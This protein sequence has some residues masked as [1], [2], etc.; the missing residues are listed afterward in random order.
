MIFDATSFDDHQQVVFCNDVASGL[1]AIIAIHRGGPKGQALG[2][3]RMI[4]YSSDEEALNDVLRLSRGMTY[5]S[6]VSNLALGGAKSVIIGDPATQK[7]PELL[8]AMGRF[9]NSLGGRYITSVD[10]GIGADDVG[11]MQ[12]VCDYAVGAGDPSPM[13]ALGVYTGVK[14]CAK[15]KLGTDDLKDVRVAVLG[16]GKVGYGLCEYLHK[17]GAKLVV[18]DVND[19][20]TSLANEKFGA[21]VTS[22]DDLISRE[23]EVFSP[24]ALGAIIN[25]DTIPKLNT[26]IIAGGANNQLA[27]DS[28]ADDLTAR[29]IL[30]APDYVINAGGVIQCDQEVNDYSE[31]EAKAR[32]E[33]IYDTL[34]RIFTRAASDG[35]TT[36]AA[37]QELASER[38]HA[39]YQEAAE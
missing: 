20:A 28:M 25:E 18:A 39:Q 19:K 27:V 38:Y 34:T 33:E 17:E 6:A 4:N 8:H 7:T 22:I 2:G 12:Q 14:A 37:A 11:I 9:V 5:K 23:V 24:C 29:G 15:A 26:K 21:A 30:Y 32:T 31:A 36:L 10:V 13:T 1:K 3:C 16:V 35:I